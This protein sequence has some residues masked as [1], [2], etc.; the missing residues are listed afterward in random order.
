[1]VNNNE[2]MKQEAFDMILAFL[3]I[4]ISFG[5]SIGLYYMLGGI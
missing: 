4:I 2:I 5:I 1:M 3:M